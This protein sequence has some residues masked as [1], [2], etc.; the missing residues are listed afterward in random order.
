MAMPLHPR[1][2]AISRSGSDSPL[3]LRIWPDAVE[4]LKTL[5]G[6]IQPETAAENDGKLYFWLESKG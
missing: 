4:L 6:E 2:P 1:T 5:S 3:H